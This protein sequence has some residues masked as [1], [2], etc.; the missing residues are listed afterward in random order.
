MVESGVAGPALEDAVE[1]GA[2]LRGAFESLGEFVVFQLAIEPPDHPL[3]DLDGVAL[4][5]VGGNELV[6]EPLGVNP[7]QGVDAD[8]ELAGVVLRR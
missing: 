7:A 6:D 4:P 1:A 8:A 2:Q 5:I 3:G